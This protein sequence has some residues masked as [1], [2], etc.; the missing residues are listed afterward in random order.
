VLKASA[1]SRIVFVA[2]QVIRALDFDDLQSEKR[3]SMN[4]AYG[5]SKLDEA[6]AKRLW[7]ISEEMTQIG[8]H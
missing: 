4:G 1:P 5:Q 2:S 8:N 3:F 6:S 7:Q